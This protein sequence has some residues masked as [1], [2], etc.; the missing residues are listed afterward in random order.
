MSPCRPYRYSGEAGQ[1]HNEDIIEDSVAKSNY[2]LGKCRGD[3]LPAGSD[4]EQGHS[5]ACL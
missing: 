5:Q 3:G 4:P 1:A 2:F